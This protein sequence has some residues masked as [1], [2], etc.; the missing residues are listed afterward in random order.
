MRRYIIKNYQMRLIRY[1]K[2]R[3]YIFSNRSYLSFEH[4]EYNITD[5]EVILLEEV[6]ENYLQDLIVQNK[7]IYIKSISKYD[8]INVN[9]D[10]KPINNYSLQEDKK[11][12]DKKSSRE[13]RKSREKRESREKE[14]TKPKK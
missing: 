10:W 4:I 9:N 2:I 5:Q 3:K 8:N 13:S 12:N 11:D 7:N 1:Y 14:K 6:L